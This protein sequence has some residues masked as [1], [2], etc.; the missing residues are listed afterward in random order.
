MVPMKPLADS[1]TRLSAHLSPSKRATLSI[2]MLRWVVQ[3]LAGSRIERVVVIGGDV[4]VETES[5]MQGAEWIRDDYLE[6][7]QA[8]KFA[9]GR[10]WGEGLSAAYIPSDL[11]LLTVQDVN[12]LI[13]ASDEGQMLT[14]CRAH[15]G[16][17]NGLIAPPNLG[18]K[19]LL[20]SDSFRRHEMLARD[21]KVE[22]RSYESD[23]FYRDIDTIEDLR[24]CMDLNPPCLVEIAEALKDLM[25]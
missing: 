12:G 9:F 3:T 14:L 11:P 10:V 23:G 19:P 4:S 13:D 20:G 24:I 18:F 7:N 22:F 16:G 5:R 8:I 25:E 15:D 17:T 2:N 1:K 21:L 6:L